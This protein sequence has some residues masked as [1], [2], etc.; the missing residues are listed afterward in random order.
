MTAP[1]AKTPD[2]FTTEGGVRGLPLYC[3]ER[4]G[5]DAWRRLQLPE[6]GQFARSA[7][8]CQRHGR[9]DAGGECQA[10]SRADAFEQRIQE[11]ELDYLTHSRAAETVLAENYVGLP[12]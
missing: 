12:Y 5:F 3:V 9:L 2:C 10:P 6:L 11:A 7:Q 1:P 4:T 8:A